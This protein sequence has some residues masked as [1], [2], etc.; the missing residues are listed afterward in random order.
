MIK[1]ELVEMVHTIVHVV[2]GQLKLESQSSVAQM[3]FLKMKVCSPTRTAHD[4]E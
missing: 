3:F 2:D 4:H 1:G